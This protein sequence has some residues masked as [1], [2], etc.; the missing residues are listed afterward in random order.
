MYNIYG[1]DS[2]I[3]YQFGWRIGI[4]KGQENKTVWSIYPNPAN[5]F[6]KIVLSNNNPSQYSISFIDITGKELF[7]KTLNSDTIDISLLTSGM[8][9][10]KLFNSKTGKLVGTQKF[11]KE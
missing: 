7:S 2:T 3:R 11:V 1:C 5:D 10:V 8:Y 6:L 9:F 4:E